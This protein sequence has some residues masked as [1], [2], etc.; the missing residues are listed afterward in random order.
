MGDRYPKQ[1]A[2]NWSDHTWAL[3]DGGTA[4]QLDPGAADDVYF[5]ANSGDVI[6]ST[7]DTDTFASLDMS[8]GASV[9]VGTLALGIFDLDTNGDISLSGTLTGTGTIYCGGGLR[10]FNLTFATSI[11]VVLDAGAGS[12]EIRTNETYGDIT[13]DAAGAEYFICQK[14]LACANLLLSAG[15]LNTR[16]YRNIACDSMTV[17]GGTLTSS[18]DFDV[19]GDFTRSAGDIN[20]TDE[21]TVFGTTKVTVYT[22]GPRNS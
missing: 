16:D 21:M 10:D 11:S 12:H 13:I 14:N 4:D 20:V 18:T 15:T 3:T 22:F 6:L 19:I 9:Y 8:Y 2:M 17:A 7:G 5:T 1:V